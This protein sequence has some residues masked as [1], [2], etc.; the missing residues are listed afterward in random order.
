MP[1]IE[2]V[3]KALEFC[4]TE[5]DY[6]LGNPCANCPYDVRTCLDSMKA[7]ALELI[8]W[9]DQ[10]IKRLEDE[11]EAVGKQMPEPDRRGA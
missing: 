7:D 8:R 9:Q 2:K 10:R 4:L 11:L 3:I 1:D 5:S 6:I